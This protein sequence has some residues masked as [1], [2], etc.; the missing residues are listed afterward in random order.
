MKINKVATLPDFQKPVWFSTRAITNILSLKSVDKQYH[1]TYDSNDQCFVVHRQDV[2][3]PDI[4]FQMHSL[5]LHYHQPDGDFSFVT[6]I[7]G[8]MLPFTKRQIESA[9]KAQALYASLSYPSMADFKWILRSNQIKDCPIT[10]NDAEIATKI[11]GPNITALKGKMVR[12][13]PDAVA[14]DVVLIPKQ[15]RELHRNVSLSIDIFFFNGIA[16]FITLSRNIRFTTVTHLPNRTV[17]EIFKAFRSIFKYYF[18]RGFQVTAVMG[19]GEFVPLEQH[20]VDLPG[21]P[22]LNLTSPNEHEPYIERHIRVVKERTRSIW[23]LLPFTHIP[24]PMLTY[25]IF[26]VVKL[27]NSFLAK[28]GISEQYS[29]KAILA[30][31]IIHYKYYTMPFGTYCQVHEEDSPQNSMS[32]R[33]QGAISLGPS[34]N[35]QGGHKFYNLTSGRIVTRR[36]WTVIPMPE[37]VIQRV[38]TLGKTQPADVTFTDRH[39]R[40]IG[41][42]DPVHTTLP[43]DKYNI[44][45]VVG[46]DVELPGVDAADETE[47]KEPPN[48]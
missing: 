27:L 46:D 48:Q 15:I 43:A 40:I 8:N 45:G 44:P 26:Y 22:K 20:M 5:G 47:Q 4:I 10:V 24:Q 9:E 13:S 12:R 28:G 29:P 16:F 1:V 41:D 30:G 25:M 36:S 19:D 42:V 6:T 35:V 2:G 33:T 23:N 11:W 32:P 34:G 37:L 17:P 39:G 14:Q 18:E 31:E 21:A 3:M 7:D 38:N